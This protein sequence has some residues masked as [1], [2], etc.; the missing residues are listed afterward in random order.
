MEGF[1]DIHCHILPGL[2]DG[3][4]RIEESLRMLEIAR[5]DGVS[6]I[7][8]TPHIKVGVHDTGI[9][10]IEKGIAVMQQYGEVPKLFIGAD[11]EISFDLIEKIKKGVVP[12]INNGRYL[13]VE[14]PAFGFLSEQFINELLFNLRLL[15]IYPII[16]HPERNILFLEHS[17]ILLGLIHHGAYCQ[18][19]AMSITG[20]FDSKIQ[21]FTASDAHDSVRRPPILSMAYQKVCKLFNEDI[22][23]KTFI[24]NPEK[25][26]EG[27]PI[28]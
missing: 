14:F 6:S 12:L 27:L 16:T 15:N 17:R 25:I 9:S 21:K 13:L 7:V 18:V 24:D 1:V 10:D 4:A 28:D 22:A 8:A 3:P 11:V 19:T 23:Q 26:L 2:D 20:E 5:K